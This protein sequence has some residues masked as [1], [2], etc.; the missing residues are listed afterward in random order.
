MLAIVKYRVDLYF[1]QSC[2][3]VIP[4]GSGHSHVHLLLEK[5]FSLKP[6][7]VKTNISAAFDKLIQIKK[8]NVAV[9]VIT[10][11][12]DENMGTVLKK[13][14]FR[15]EIVLIRS[16]DPMERHI[17]FRGFLPVKDIE[18]GQEAIIDVRSFK[19][20]KLQNF[21]EHQAA[22]QV[23]LMKKYDIEC[24]DIINH[25]TFIDDVIRFF[26]RRM[27]YLGN[28]LMN[29][30]E[31]KDFYDIYQMWH[32]PWWQ[33]AAVKYGIAALVV[34]VLCLVLWCVIT[35]IIKRRKRQTP[36]DYALSSL[37]VLKDSKFFNESLA[38]LFYANLTNIIKI[39]CE[40]R[41][42][43]DSMGKTD[44]ELLSYL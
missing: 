8:R 32:K 23:K 19:R 21:L 44:N 37:Q 17:P 38:P 39:Y 42:N 9:F 18:T 35:I 34:I 24:L 30:P 6:Q 43:F 11:G 40:N 7:G 13:A 4:L 3:T 10:D 22:E 31:M 14:S 29:M 27:A 25:E 15:Y 5:I 36:W 12:I 33:H 20:N 41:F 26:R 1:I 2:R 28:L 16:G